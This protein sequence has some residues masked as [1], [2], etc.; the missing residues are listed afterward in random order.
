MIGCRIQRI[1]HLNGMTDG[2][3][4]NHEE[5]EILFWRRDALTK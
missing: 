4:F 1:S 5:G 2:R 3:I